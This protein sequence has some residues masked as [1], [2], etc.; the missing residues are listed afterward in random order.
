LT[1]N[2]IIQDKKAYAELVKQVTPNSKTLKNVVRAFVCGGLVCC[3]GQGISEL[4]SGSIPDQKIRSA[5]VTIILIF[6]G[7]LLTAL[8]VYD[9]IAKFACAGTLV[10]VTGFANSVTASAIEFKSEGFIG[11]M[12]TKMFIIAGPV[13]VFGIAASAVYGI[14][15]LL[16][17]L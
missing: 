14:I 2:S 12:S 9:H 13:I 8:H 3:I 16:G 4:L 11:G 10:P 1:N 5:V 17:S 7:A 6:L 15:L